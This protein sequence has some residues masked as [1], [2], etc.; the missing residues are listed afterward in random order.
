[1]VVYLSFSG[2]KRL[3]YPFYQFS[4]DISPLDIVVSPTHELADAYADASHPI[5]G[6]RF[7]QFLSSYEPVHPQSTAKEPPDIIELVSNFTH[8]STPTASHL[9]TLLANP[10]QGY[11]P[12]NTSLIIIDS[13]ST[14]ISNAF[15]KTVDSTANPRNAGCKSHD[16]SFSFHRY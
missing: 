9:I 2:T 4:V 6:A 15:P 7:S 13:F 1:M 12:S 10:T 3:D 8:F 16:T 14:L 11:P 5:S